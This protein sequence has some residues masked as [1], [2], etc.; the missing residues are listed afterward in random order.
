MS[1]TA[2]SV[3]ARG[4]KM[5]CLVVASLLV[6]L[7]SA[8]SEADLDAWARFKAEHGKQYATAEDEAAR[9]QT[10]LERKEEVESHNRLYEQGLTTYWMGLNHLSDLTH[11]E[12][13]RRHSGGAR[14]TVVAAAAAAGGGSKAGSLPAHVDWRQH[15]LVTPP[16]TQG[17]CGGCW[18]FSTTGAVEGQ[19]AKKTG[20]LYSFSEQQLID[21]TGT[22]N[23]ANGGWMTVAYEYI[24]KAGG[25]E[26]E[27]EYP[28]TGKD[29]QKCKFKKSLAKGWVKGIV[30]LPSGDEHR[31]ALAVSEVG[32]IAA[33]MDASAS[34]FDNYAGGIYNEPKCS[35]TT[36]DHGVLI[37]GYGSENGHDYWIVKNSWGPKYGEKG[38]IRI[39]RNK[40]NKCALATAAN[41]PTA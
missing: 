40:H 2:E 26:T 35:N 33:G 39:A 13:K 4:F 7:T 16:K 23:C 3:L 27:Q 20:K 9:L 41:Y 21:C 28:F 17:L 19:I 22:M 15:N 1:G 12:I 31:L 5:R 38:Y 36:M 24:R 8:A 10:F 29:G 32:P 14:K 34:S 37:V 18:A 30:D 11:E 6:A 25:I